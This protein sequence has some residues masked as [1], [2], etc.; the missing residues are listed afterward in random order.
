MPGAANCNEVWSSVDGARWTLETEH[1]GWCLRVSPA[2][3]VY[4]NRMWIMAGTENF[5]DDN[6]DT[7][8]N[9]V[10]SSSDGTMWSLEADSAA[11]PQR[12]HAQAVLFSGRIW[13]AGGYGE[14]LDSQ[15]WSLHVPP[16]LLDDE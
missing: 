6:L 14:V 16:E 15:V 1:A 10:W 4:E 5:Y 9:D 3:A 11:W 7:L 12:T 13:T 8:K 2:F